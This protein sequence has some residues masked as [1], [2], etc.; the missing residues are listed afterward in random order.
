MGIDTELIDVEYII[1]RRKIS[2]DSDFPMKRIQTFV[3]ASGKP[4]RNKVGQL[5]VEFINT[6]FNEEGLHNKDIEYPAYKSSA[7]KYCKYKDN[8]ELCP[9]V[10]RM[11]CG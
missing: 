2:E 9:A 5:L 6:G 1:L 8:Q 4:S 7:C 3:P 11:M 10:K